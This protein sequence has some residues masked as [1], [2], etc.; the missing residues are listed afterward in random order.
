[1][2]ACMCVCVSVRA[3]LD[4]THGIQ[5]YN[6]NTARMRTCLC[7]HIMGYDIFRPGFMWKMQ[8][9]SCFGIWE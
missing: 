7:V 4:V 3:H 6:L 1:M 5:Y 2:S 8:Y 9:F